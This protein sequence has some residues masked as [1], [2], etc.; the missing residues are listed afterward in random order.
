MG[1]AL[2]ISPLRKGP[3]DAAGESKSL[4]EIV[5]QIDNQKDFN[6]YILNKESDP[7]AIAK[8]QVK[9]ERHPV[10]LPLVYCDSIR[11]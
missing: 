6:D 1:Q 11:S 10:S 7:G 4:H 5:G 8:E 3:S 2:C 9:Y